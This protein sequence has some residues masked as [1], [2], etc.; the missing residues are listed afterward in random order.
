MIGMSASESQRCRGMDSSSLETA[1]RE[2]IFVKPVI[3]FDWDGTLADS[4][5]LC[6]AEVRGTLEKMG[7]AP[8]TE[9]QI[10]RCNGPAFDACVEILDVPREMAAE[11][12]RVRQ[13]TELEI[14]ETEQKLFPGIP[15]MIADLRRVAEVA[16]VSNGM[17][18]Y[19][20]RSLKA[21]G[22]DGQFVRW[23]AF[24]TGRTKTQALAQMLEEM[25]PSA[26]CMVGDCVGDIEAGKANGLYTLGAGYG[27]GTPE[28]RSCADM[29][30][31]SVTE[32][33]ELLYAWA[34]SN[35]DNTNKKE[36]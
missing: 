14:I 20:R 30:A 19:I 34:V 25:K 15:E 23:E 13:E 17:P 36:A 24:R 22:L 31:G 18:E 7:L 27:Y 26:A 32:L 8:R 16:I 9:E 6:F 2:E 1:F 10:R 21:M 28:E 4:M 3:Y 29:I 33:K 11:F 35:T 5:G 12:L